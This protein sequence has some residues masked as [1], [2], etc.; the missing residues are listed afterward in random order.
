MKQVDIYKEAL[1]VMKVAVVVRDD[2]GFRYWKYDGVEFAGLCSLLQGVP[3][4]RCSS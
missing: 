1:E 2:F 3:S 4:V